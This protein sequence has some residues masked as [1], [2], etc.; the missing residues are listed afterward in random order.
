M[1]K[2]SIGEFADDVVLFTSQYVKLTR[3]SSSNLEQTHKPEN[4]VASS[5][6]ELLG[7]SNKRKLL[8][9]SIPTKDF[10]ADKI[11]KIKLHHTKS[12]TTLAFHPHERIIAGGDESGRIL[13]WRGFGNAKFSGESGAKSSVDDGRDGVR[14]DDDADSC[15]TLHWHSSRVNFLKF[16]SDGA[17]LFSGFCY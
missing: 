16:S 4:I 3:I 15:T 17:Y 11:R 5:S 12:L 1:I 7:I 13:I 9:W 10:K 2:F 14:G 6:G 8:V